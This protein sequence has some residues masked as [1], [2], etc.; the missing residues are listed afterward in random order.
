MY[1]IRSYYDRHKAV[2][3]RIFPAGENNTAR[4][5][6]EYPQSAVT[7]GQGAVFYDGDAVAGAGW[8]EPAE[9]GI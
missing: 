7:P 9:T 4:I 5:V 1:A 6:F 8:I 2:L 3:A